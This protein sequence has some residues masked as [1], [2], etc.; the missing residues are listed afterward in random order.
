MIAL[1]SAPGIAYALEHGELT[2]VAA[3]RAATFRY[4]AVSCRARTRWL[5]REASP[6]APQ[7]PRL[8]DRTPSGT[9]PRLIPSVRQQQGHET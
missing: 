6:P 3:Q 1:R 7:Q 5:P 4:A 8:L 9:R 2:M